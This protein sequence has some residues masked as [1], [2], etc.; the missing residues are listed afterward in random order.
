M[1]FQAPPAQGSVRSELLVAIKVIVFHVSHE[2]VG[3]RFLFF[4]FPCRCTLLPHLVPF[5]QPADRF[6]R[7]GVID[8]VVLRHD[9]QEGLQ[10]AYL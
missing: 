6:P 9:L 4:C 1:N 10:A 5:G 3:N 8:E 2:R 7:S